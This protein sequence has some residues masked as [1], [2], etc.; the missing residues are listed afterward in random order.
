MTPV[1]KIGWATIIFWVL[2]E[3]WQYNPIMAAQPIVNTKMLR[4]RI[5]SSKS[6]FTCVPVRR[7]VTLLIL[8]HVMRYHQID[9]LCCVHVRRGIMVVK[10]IFKLNVASRDAA[11]K[12]GVVKWP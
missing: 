7:R 12:Q 6:Y 5:L 8:R 1:L 4:L 2:L 10:S 9:N 11:T 3:C